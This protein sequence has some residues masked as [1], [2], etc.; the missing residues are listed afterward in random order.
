[1]AVGIIMIIIELWKQRCKNRHILNNFG[2][3]LSSE[4]MDFSLCF[5]VCV[6]Y[7]FAIMNHQVIKMN[8]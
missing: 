3:L 5:T 7:C 8:K 6:Q 4:E 1:M 2:H